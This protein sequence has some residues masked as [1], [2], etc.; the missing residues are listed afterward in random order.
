[1][2]NFIKIG[3]SDLCSLVKKYALRCTRGWLLATEK[4]KKKTRPRE[5]SSDR[6]SFRPNRKLC[7][8]Y[9]AN[10]NFPPVYRTRGFVSIK[11]ADRQ[12]ARAAAT[13]EEREKW[14]SRRDYPHGVY[15]DCKKT[16]Y[17]PGAIHECLC[18]ALMDET[19]SRCPPWTYIPPLA[20]SSSPHF[21]T[22]FTRPCAF[23]MV[24]AAITSL[25]DE[26]L[27]LRTGWSIWARIFLFELCVTRQKVFFTQHEWHRKIDDI[28]DIK[29]YFTR[30]F[31]DYY[32]LRMFHFSRRFWRSLIQ[33][34]VSFLLHH[35]AGRENIVTPTHRL[36]MLP[37]KSMYWSADRFV[38]DRQYLKRESW[39]GFWLVQTYLC[40]VYNK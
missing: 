10:R 18:T 1:M 16:Q 13:G 37:L 19:I 17:R 33:S 34:R 6:G 32:Y 25:R 2:S 28:T 30:L 31:Y 39:H 23:S 40:C 21:W 27:A 20:T 14:P 3:D 26:W 24:E 15:E 8:Q 29:I 9:K 11:A 7:S 38:S 35:V 22:T 5:S 12:L 36:K 4:K